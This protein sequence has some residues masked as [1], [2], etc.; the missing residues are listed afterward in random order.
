MERTDAVA[1]LENF[2]QYQRSKEESI[3]N[4]MDQ[5]QDNRDRKLRELKEKQERRKRHAEEVRKRKAQARESGIA[6]PT[7]EEHPSGDVEVT[8][9]PEMASEGLPASSGDGLPPLLRVEEAKGAKGG[10][11]EQQPRQQ[12]RWQRAKPSRRVRAKEDFSHV[13]VEAMGAEEEGVLRPPHVRWDFL[14]QESVTC[15]GRGLRR[16]V[17]QNFL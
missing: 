2:A 17:E 15:T 10:Q 14:A 8:P 5:V 16:L 9:R 4:R 13:L 3:A 6:S 7:F 11:A 12:P 1:A